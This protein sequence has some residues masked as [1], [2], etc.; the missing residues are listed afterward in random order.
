MVKR[1]CYFFTM[2]YILLWHYVFCSHAIFANKNLRDFSGFDFGFKQLKDIYRALI[3][4][5]T[6]RVI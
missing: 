6:F 1:R 5:T 3:V 4:K 2:G